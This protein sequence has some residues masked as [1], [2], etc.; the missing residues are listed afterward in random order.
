[1]EELLPNYSNWRHKYSKA[2][3]I[4]YFITIIM[5]VVIFLLLKS[6]NMILET[7]PVYV[8][9]YFI[10]PIL[11]NTIVC[12][13]SI[14]ALKIAKQESV[15]NAIPVLTLTCMVGF[16][17][18]I[19]NVFFVTLLLFIIPIFMTVVFGDKKLLW[20][21]GGLSIVFIFGVVYFCFNHTQASRSNPYFLP[22]VLIAIVGV[23][24]CCGIASTLIDLLNRQNQ[25][26]VRAVDEATKANQ[27]KSAFLYNMSHEIRTPMN[28][29]IGLTDI[30]LRNPK[31]EKEAK[32][33]NNIKHSGSALTTIVNDILDF[34]KIET[35]QLVLKEDIYSF[36]G[37]LDDLSMI[38][39]SLIGDKDIELL[40]D[41]DK[42]LP[43]LLYGD[44]ARVRQ[45]I[46]NLVNN[47]VKFTEKG[48]VKL[49]VEV[50]RY[51]GNDNIELAVSVTDSGKGVKEEEAHLMFKTFEQINTRRD[52]KQEG[53]GL[54]LAI[55]KQLVSM[56][57]GAI[58]FNSEFG[59]GS[60]FSFTICQKMEERSDKRYS[61]LKEYLAD[62]KIG[63][64]IKGEYLK[65]SVLDMFD[66]IDIEV[67]DYKDGVD[68]CLC[69]EV[70]NHNSEE[71]VILVNP[72]S[73]IDPNETA[74]LL[75]KPVYLESLCRLWIDNKQ[76]AED[77][78]EASKEVSYEGKRI[79]IAED[80]ELN[81]EVVMLLL[82]P[83]GIIA[84]VAENGAVAC[85]MVK[86][87]HYD[88]VLMDYMM[89]EMDG[90]EAAKCIRSMDGEYF[91][92]LPII[93]LTANVIA[94]AKEELINSGMNDVATKPIDMKQMT[95]LLNK[96]I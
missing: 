83:M 45:I 10:A 8:R 54:G 43:E 58:S 91:K 88:M 72:Y 25:K 95:D 6:N 17:A 96:W 48:F 12:T 55:S 30:L 18:I 86:N 71:R 53:T 24:V 65:K 46:L 94:E 78:K 93:A 37:M 77:A 61:A 80:N 19:H 66:K 41:I 60:T 33:L 40:Y 21:T 70:C 47:A 79:L 64:D 76:D 5:E 42:D 85:E 75:T 9:N 89:P 29:I 87:N 7:I 51:L 4:V 27:A 44:E 90:A 57:D 74:G 23:L 14:F 67:S 26:L 28:A 92:K 62:K 22:S 56:M 35:G 11:L 20:I 38:I 82:E 68:I 36:K 50:G 31:D 69:D 3:A 63:I 15:K 34:S 39:W 59:V 84:D 52:H 2:V 16:I 49:T 1:M 13:I 81:R 73:E 32:Y